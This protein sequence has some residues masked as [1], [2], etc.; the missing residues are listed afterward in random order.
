MIQFRTLPPIDH[1]DLLSIR[2]RLASVVHLLEGANLFITGG[3]G[4]LGRWLVEA[5]LDLESNFKLG[6]NLTILSR[7][8]D[9]FMDL[10]PHLKRSNNIQ[11]IRGDIRRFTFPEKNFTHI[12]HGATS[13][14][15]KLNSNDPIEMY[16][17]I[18]NGTKFI[19][20]YASSRNT[21]RV[22]TLSTSN[23]YGSDQNYLT[24]VFEECNISPDPYN[25]NSAYLEGKRV[26]EFLCAVYAEKNSTKFP[27][28]RLFHQI[29]PHIP[30]HSGNAAGDFIK[31]VLQ[32]MPI[33]LQ[34]DG[35]NFRSYMYSSDF[36]VW[37][38]TLLLKGDSKAYNVG[39]E[40]G[41]YLADIAKKIAIQYDLQIQSKKPIPKCLD[42]KGVVPS[43]QRAFNEFN[44]TTEVDFI[45]AVT[46]TV[47]WYRKAMANNI[48][49]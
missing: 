14:D 37:I 22:L 40:R 45:E 38:Y 32:S 4:F 29:G 23:I 39:S 7:N 36:T 26:A 43:T 25:K 9:A 17:V 15:P 2:Q 21:S 48:H 16:E 13:P 34:S 49:W 18:T 33:L 19:L 47:S 20:D 35:S 3:T 1:E 28:A 30:L 24:H 31:N 10:L 6:C 46:K 5:F 8:P 44:L 41:L 11:F 12:I 27:V 42:Q